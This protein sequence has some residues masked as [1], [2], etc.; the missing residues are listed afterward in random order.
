MG[1]KSGGQ[2]IGYWY[3]MDILATICH[4][5]VDANTD[6]EI[7][8]FR[9][10]DRTG[11]TGNV[12]TSGSISIYEKYLFGGESREGGVEGTVDIMMGTLDQPINEF[13]GTSMRLSNIAGPVPAYRGEI[14][15]FF[16]GVTT[17]N[18]EFPT[19]G[20]FIAQPSERPDGYDPYADLMEAFNGPGSVPPSR[21]FRWS[22]MN[23]Y[24]KPF[25]VLL[26]RY[27]KGWYSAK[28]R[29]GEQSNPAHIIVEC[30]TNSEWGMGYPQAD[31]D[32]TRF[33]SAADVLHS[34]G[35]GL[36]LVWRQQT[37]IQEFI[38][39]VL[40]HINGV[41]NTDRSTGKLFLRLIRNDYTVSSLKE[42][43]RTNSVLENYSRPTFGETVNEVTIK[44]TTVNGDT[45]AVT[46]QDLAGINSNQGQIVSQTLEMP[47]ID[48]P[49]LAAKVAQ[50][51]L[52]SRCKPICKLTLLTNRVAFD[53]YE[54]E[55][56][57]FSWPEHGIE[58]MICRVV[59]VDLGK[60]QD[61]M[62][63]VE[64]IEDVF[65]MPSASYV[66]PQTSGWVN[67]SNPPAI[68]PV[69]F[70]TETPY[71]DLARELTTAD[72]ETIDPTDCSID[73]FSTEPSRDALDYNLWTASG[74]ADLVQRGVGTHAPSGQLTS[75]LV[76]EE[77]S[78]LQ[79]NSIYD[80]IYSLSNQNSYL[81]INGE[82]MA[83][84]SWNPTSNTIN[85]ARGVLDTVPKVHAAGS[86][87]MLGDDT[88]GR[89]Q[90]SYVPGEIVKVKVQTR[91]ARGVLNILSAPEDTYTFVG[92][93]NK[94]YPPGRLRLNGAAYP[95]RISG[96]LTIEFANR[97]RLTQIG[98]I[99]AQDVASITP[100]TG[101]L[102]K[103]VVKGEGNV[104]LLNTNV[105]NTTVEVTLEN[106]SASG[107]VD[108]AA[109]RS[110]RSTGLGLVTGAVATAITAANRPM[111][112]VNGGRMGVNNTNGVFV[113]TTTGTTTTRAPG[114]SGTSSSSLFSLKPT[115][116]RSSNQSDPF[117]GYAVY[118]PLSALIVSD[119]RISPPIRDRRTNPNFIIC[120]TGRRAALRYWAQTQ[121]FMK[122]IW[123]VDVGYH[124]LQKSAVMSGPGGTN[125][126]QIESYY[127]GD[128]AQFD[129]PVTTQLAIPSFG[130]A[131]SDASGDASFVAQIGCIFGN[132]FYVT[133]IGASTA[134][135]TSGKV[136]DITNVLTGHI[137]VV[138]NRVDRTRLYSIDSAG[139]TSVIS[140]R[141]SVVLADQVTGSVGVEAEGTTLRTVDMTTGAPGSTIA[142]AAGAVC[143]ICGDVTN[144]EFYVL[145]TAGILYK[146]NVAGSLLASITLSIY[147]SSSNP[148]LNS[149]IH[150]SA[151]SVFVKDKNSTLHQLPKNLSTQRVVELSMFGG[152]G[153]TS[154]SSIY[155]ESSSTEMY[156][157]PSGAVTV[158]GGLVDES[159]ASSIIPNLAT[160]RYN[161]TVTVELS[162]V[163]NGVNSHTT[164]IFTTKRQGMGLRMGESMGG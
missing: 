56:F 157:G 156:W 55:V 116:Y 42:L 80:I 31:L 79:L 38:S 164:N 73:V 100:E 134:V 11:W 90:I 7:K 68:S 129:S 126:V 135:N 70:I 142:T 41:I 85:V 6:F 141:N 112:K 95:T 89:D 5:K 71:Y 128:Q 54:G 78:T 1:G 15:L 53:L 23:P 103:V 113:D 25:K 75:A 8:E 132:L 120:L 109:N 152:I 146:Y 33:Q 18:P 57:K 145:T 45:D 161:D 67:P 123:S 83:I 20:V 13:L 36:G 101:Q 82:Y 30:L 92:R 106:E 60:L 94:P 84:Q 76:Q 111:P 19:S 81:I 98:D 118:E 104:V 87:V 127:L 105:A 114:F 69:Q 138:Q 4:G 159:G 26:A 22:A 136:V 140:T 48:N 61:N 65:G 51:E 148:Y 144:S 66:N 10:G 86:I 62:I 151:E 102:S 39:V 40:Q 158:T 163:R 35:F 16:R 9:F 124:I 63:R 59:E 37:S 58:Q 117:V 24:F 143:A 139:V 149:E 12:T 17:A 160:P 52:E 122:S 74:S 49:T 154:I 115:V 162:S 47:G 150:V 108:A 32:L 147:G 91:T 28:S 137:D 43:N 50:R 133:Y 64:A 131:L 125:R 93:Q 130:G 155:A 34:E 44:Y 29:I 88:A 110:L 119:S 97:N 96:L 77:F 107:V 153:L 2:T 72:L 46:V 27:W 21:A 14:N 99:V 121:N 3:D